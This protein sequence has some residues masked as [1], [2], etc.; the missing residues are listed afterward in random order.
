MEVEV[1]N[2]S[3]IKHYINDESVLEYSRFELGGKVDA[4]KELW[5]SRVGKSLSKGY[6]SLQSESHPCEFRNIEIL[7]L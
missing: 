6:I 4:N 7:E 5:E 3:I 1:R 2:D